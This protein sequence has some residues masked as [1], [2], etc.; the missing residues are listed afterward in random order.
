MQEIVH[1]PRGDEVSA[2][3]A[4]ELRV[5][6]RGI[7]ELGIELAQP[8]TRPFA[9]CRPIAAHLT[10]VLAVVSALRHPTHWVDA[11]LDGP[12]G[13]RGLRPRPEV[14]ALLVAKVRQDLE[15]RPASLVLSR[16]HRGVVDGL[17]KRY[18]D[19]RERGML[20]YET[21]EVTFL[22]IPS[23][24]RYDD[25]VEERITFPVERVRRRRYRVR[26][27]VPCAEG[28]LATNATSTATSGTSMDP[29]QRCPNCVDHE[30][31]SVFGLGAAHVVRCSGCGLQFAA[32]Y[33]DL[34][35]VGQ[36]IYGPDYFARALR[37]QDT[38]RHIF[39]RLLDDMESVLT[40]NETPRR[41][42][43]IGAGE[44][45]LLA[46]ATERGWHAEGIDV[47]SDMV[48]HVRDTLGLPMQQGTLEQAMLTPC[49][50]DA[51]VMNH[52]LEHV[53]DPGETL[54]RVASLLVPGGVL[55]IEVPNVGSLSSQ[56]KNAQSR[57]G[58]KRHPWKHYSVEHH[59]WFF[60]PST[61]RTTIVRSGLEVLRLATPARQ[62][63]ASPLSRHLANPIYDH[64]GW[65]KHIAAYARRPLGWREAEPERP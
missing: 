63:D 14:L 62:W 24:G 52:V 21:I 18:H 32:T 51:I 9:L 61:L 56:L 28:R 57:L 27:G 55:R 6:D 58:L 39:I 20:F 48:R 12:A 33:P 5:V 42:L 65:G 44:G 23:L 54:Q 41:L 49:S 30:V 25:T 40:R 11:G 47:A 16:P 37:E 43:D 64:F 38:R 3:H 13:R 36:E 1:A 45:T 53:R 26:G 19:A 10:R 31:K 29:E 4:P 8:D 46:V 15:R 60:T 7:E 59:F 22:H 35:A 17:D 34:D 50:F 2:P